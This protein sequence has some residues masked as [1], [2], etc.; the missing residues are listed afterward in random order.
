GGVSE[1]APAPLGVGPGP[2]LRQPFGLVAVQPGVGL[3]EAPGHG[4]H[5]V[6]VLQ[7]GLTLSQG[8]DFVQPLTVAARGLGRPRG[9]HAEALQVHQA[10]HAGRPN[11]GVHHGHVAAHAVSD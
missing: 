11:A 6:V 4:L 10:A 1:D 7:R 8:A 2:L 9:R 3:H 5:I